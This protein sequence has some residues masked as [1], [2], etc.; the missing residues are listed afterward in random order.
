MEILGIPDLDL[1]ERS[2]NMDH[3]FDTDGSPFLI[4]DP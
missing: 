3:Y 4:E 2:R 1:V